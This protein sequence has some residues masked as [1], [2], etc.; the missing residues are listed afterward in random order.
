MKVSP[1]DVSHALALGPKEAAAAEEKAK[2]LGVAGKEPIDPEKLRLAREFEQ[3]FI[4]KMLSSL[5]KSGKATSGSSSS[6]NDAYSSMVVSALAEAVSNAG[7]VGLADVIAR[8]A[9]LPSSAP[10]RAASPISANTAPAALTNPAGT[11]LSP[12]PPPAAAVPSSTAPAGATYPRPAPPQITNETN[13]I[14]SHFK[15]PKARP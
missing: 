5:E 1:L 14:P 4:R 7:G 13:D 11:S 15:D 2:A 10:V 3:I 9:S 12:T 8:S 6:S